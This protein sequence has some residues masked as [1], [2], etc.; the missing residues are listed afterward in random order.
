MMNLSLLYQR[1]RLS[2]ATFCAGASGGAATTA[3]DSM[4]VGERLDSK[5][6][7][8]LRFEQCTFADISFKEAQI[9]ACSFLDCDFIDCYFRKSLVTKCIFTSTKFQDCDFSKIKVR[10]CE[11]KYATFEA[12]FVDF[13]K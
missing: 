7:S 5:T 10:E 1:Q 4:F 3:K 13:T 9:E 6:L 8:G 2:L 11:F 12:C